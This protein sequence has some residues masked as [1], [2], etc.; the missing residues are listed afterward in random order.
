MRSSGLG[1]L[2]TTIS[3]YSN[4]G[5]TALGLLDDVAVNAALP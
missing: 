1:N 3:G 2:I 5:A 4:V